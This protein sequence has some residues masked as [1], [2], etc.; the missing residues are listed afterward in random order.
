[1]QWRCRLHAPEVFVGHRNARL[2]VHGRRLA[3]TARSAHGVVRQCSRASA[4]RTAIS[5]R[6]PRCGRGSSPSHPQ[7]ALGFPGDGQ[8]EHA[9]DAIGEPGGD[10]DGPDLRQLGDVASRPSAT[11]RMPRPARRVARRRWPVPR[12][13]GLVST[14]P[15]RS[16]ALAPSAMLPAGRV[17]MLSTRPCERA[18]VATDPR[19]C[20]ARFAAPPHAGPTRERPARGSASA[21]SNGR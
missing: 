10:L 15:A 13:H 1:M 3:S 21:V 6:R 9:A 5:A 12:V 16:T 14:A 20:T 11:A 2:T 17:A 19:G 18:S 8:P 4:W 7:Q